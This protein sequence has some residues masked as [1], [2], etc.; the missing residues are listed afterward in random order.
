[1]SFIT[2]KH[3]LFISSYL[4]NEVLAMTAE[5]W[6]LEKSWSKLVIL[7][8]CNIFFLE[9]SLPGPEHGVVHH[10]LLLVLL[11]SGEGHD[12]DCPVSVLTVSLYQD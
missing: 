7:D 3:S 11:L 2:A 8:N 1:M 12:L 9:G 6:M 4:P 5:S 10:H